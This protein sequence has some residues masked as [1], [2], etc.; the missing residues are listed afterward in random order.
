MR[1]SFLFKNQNWA[2]LSK[3]EKGKDF[4]AQSALFTIIFLSVH[5][6]FPDYFDLRVFLATE[7]KLLRDW[8]AYKYLS[9][10]QL[11]GRV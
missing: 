3:T 11:R 2:K 4:N 1:F 9:K 5:C 7:E 8:N 10:Y 6:D